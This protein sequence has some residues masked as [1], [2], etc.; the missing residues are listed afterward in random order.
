MVAD[1]R[2]VDFGLNCVENMAPEP[3]TKKI[4]EC[5]NIKLQTERNNTVI[6]IENYIYIYIYAHNVF[7]QLY[8]HVTQFYLFLYKIICFFMLRIG[9]SHR[10]LCSISLN[11]NGNSCVNFISGN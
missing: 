2:G 7:V 5:V 10:L 4:K 9:C 1:G 8:M 3:F 11:Y 6:I